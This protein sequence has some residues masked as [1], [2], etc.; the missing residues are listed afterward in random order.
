M[1]YILL[2]SYINQYHIANLFHYIS[3]RSILAMIISFGICF[4]Y[5]SKLIDFYLNNPSEASRISQN[6]RNR[7][8]KEHTSKIRLKNIIDQI[9]K[10]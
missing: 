10:I 7:F 9:N 4:S 3:F 8:L 5:G 2:K 6:G 1:I